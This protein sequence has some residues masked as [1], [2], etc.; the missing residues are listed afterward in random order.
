MSVFDLV[1]PIDTHIYEC[2]DICIA[3]HHLLTIFLYVGH[4]KKAQEEKQNKKQQ[5]QQRLRQQNQ[6]EEKP[7]AFENTHTRFS[8]K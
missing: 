3:L 2:I 6:R 7:I 8:I 1:K 5:Q 4:T